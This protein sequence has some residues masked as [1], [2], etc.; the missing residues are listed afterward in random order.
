[1]T[2]KP[3]AAQTIHC[4]GDVHFGDIAGF[5]FYP[6]RRRI[7][8]DDLASSLVPQVEHHV[9]FGDLTD[10]GAT[11]EDAAGLA[12]L[13]S[14]G[15]TKH[16]VMGNHDAQPGYTRTKA[17]CA[18]AWGL[19]SLDYVHDL[20]FATL[21]AIA[22]DAFNVGGF[23][24]SFNS[25]TLAWLSDQ[26]A[27]ATSP[28][29][30][31]AHPPLY[32]T[33]GVGGSADQFMSNTTNYSAQPDTDIRSMLASHDTPI[34]WVSGHTHTALKEPGI[35]KAEPV[36]GGRTVAA[37]NCSAL[38]YTGLTSDWTDELNSLFLTVYDDRF[39]VRF[40]NHG[41][42]QWVGYGPDRIQI[43]TVPFS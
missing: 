22:P 7:V 24:I 27:A 40:R 15:G 4:M 17:Q 26:I 14:L 28:V 41:A 6:E 30:I 34:A 32:N 42:R 43:A 8:T 9:Q 38:A 12:W 37:V 21:I 10:T 16:L 35:V 39:E 25:T 11:S 18:A 36:G 1:M 29:I 20:G 31:A 33:V 19:P 3:P 23:L 2:R 5:R 13:D